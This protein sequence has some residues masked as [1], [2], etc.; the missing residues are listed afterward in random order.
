MEVLGGAAG[1]L[2][3]DEA[4]AEFFGIDFENDDLLF[5]GEKLCGDGIYLLLAAKVDEG[6]IVG[7]VF[8]GGALLALIPVTLCHDFVDVVGDNLRRGGEQSSCCHECKDE[9]EHDVSFTV[10]KGETL[11]QGE[12][13]SNSLDGCLRILPVPPFKLVRVMSGV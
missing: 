7:G 13:P 6:G 8:E 5:F 3:F 11:R 2:F 1:V 12:F 10:V 4:A 9:V